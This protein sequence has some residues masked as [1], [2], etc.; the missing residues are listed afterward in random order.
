MAIATTLR[1]DLTV[2][3]NAQILKQVNLIES[4]S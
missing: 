2:K 3:N 4:T 1:V